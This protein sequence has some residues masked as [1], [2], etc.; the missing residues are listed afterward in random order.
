MY[1]RH[2]FTLPNAH[3]LS[4]HH[5]SLTVLHPSTKRSL[6]IDIAAIKSESKMSFLPL[7][8]RSTSSNRSSDGNPA[9]HISIPSLKPA[10][11]QPFD[12]TFFS[13]NGFISLYNFII[14]PVSCGFKIKRFIFMPMSSSTLLLSR[15]LQI[16]AT[17]SP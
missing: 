16:F 6:I 8:I 14:Q 12:I 4:F 11:S 10:F 17:N 5:F 13:R 2:H 9:V 15:A 3:P 1:I 7:T